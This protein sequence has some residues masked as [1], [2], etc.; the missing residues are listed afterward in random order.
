MHDKSLKFCGFTLIMGVFGAFFRWVQS[1]SAYE[2]DTG[3]SISGSAWNYILMAFLLV[4]ALS[5]VFS[6]RAFRKV[7]FSGEFSRAF[8]L[9]SPLEGMLGLVLAALMGAGGLITLILSLRPPLA[10]FDTIT[11]AFSIIS[12]LCFAAFLRSAGRDHANARGGAAS[13]VIVLFL[14]FWLIATYKNFAYE[15]VIWRFAPRILAICAAIL[16]YY[17]L[18]G[19]PY[20]K[21]KPMLCL[22]F[23]QLGAFLLI[24]TLA[25][26]FSLGE[27]LIAL[28][29]AVGLLLLSFIILSRALSQKN[30]EK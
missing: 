3:L 30:E 10:V 25:D 7:G 14:C 1:L 16:G 28:S 29:F 11:G 22:Y 15:P 9:G 12:A 13:L 20:G 19:Y 27:Q 4:C 8:R 26:P 5:F 21:P 17:Y 18:A 23:C 24:V 6:V 2:P